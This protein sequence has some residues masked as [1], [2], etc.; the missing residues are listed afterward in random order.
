MDKNLL[1][2]LSPEAQKILGLVEGNEF[3]FN[4]EKISI[5]GLLD[6][7][8]SIRFHLKWLNN[9]DL[10]QP[11]KQQYPF[12]IQK[13][14]N[15][16]L[17][18]AVY[19][20]I[21]PENQVQISVQTFINKIPRL[22]LHDIN[23]LQ[24]TEQPPPPLKKKSYQKWLFYGAELNRGRLDI[25]ACLSLVNACFVFSRSDYTSDHPLPYVADINFS[26]GLVSLILPFLNLGTLIYQ[27]H[28]KYLKDLESN[29]KTLQSDVFFQQKRQTFYKN[30]INLTLNISTFLISI[31]DLFPMHFYFAFINIGIDFVFYSWDFYEKHLQFLKLQEQQYQNLQNL[32]SSSPK[33]LNFEDY[34]KKSN[35]ERTRY[36]VDI[37]NNTQKNPSK[38]QDDCLYQIILLITEEQKNINAQKKLLLEMITILVMFAVLIIAQNILFPGL[39]PELTFLTGLLILYIYHS[40]KSLLIENPIVKLKQSSIELLD[41]NG[42]VF[43]LKGGEISRD[44]T[45]ED[46]AFFNLEVIQTLGIKL[47]LP[48]CGIVMLQFIAPELAIPIFFALA[49]CIKLFELSSKKPTNLEAVPSK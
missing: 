4:P 3:L 10:E 46:N 47:A 35:V 37:Y 11:L 27:Y 2:S 1:E 24:T 44:Q 12:V 17:L 8:A 23:N 9:I 7:E 15:L 22:M 20:T 14:Q 43:Y 21:L 49:I 31:L 16:L 42:N 25:S 34:L 13:I 45:F 28:E 26:F 36:L 39:N 48:I 18:N 6:I 5:Q 38:N 29:F 30:I 41:T 19:N 40:L 33:L 32:L